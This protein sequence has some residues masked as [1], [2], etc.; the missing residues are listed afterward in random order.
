MKSLLQFAIVLVIVAAASIVSLPPARAGEARVGPSPWSR[1]VDGTKG[2][3]RRTPKHDDQPDS[4]ADGVKR[5]TWNEPQGRGEAAAA[6]TKARQKPSLRTPRAIKTTR[7][8]L[9]EYMAQERP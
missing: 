3:L 9:S 8:T 6:G 5:A 1:L 4:E 2:M 7:R